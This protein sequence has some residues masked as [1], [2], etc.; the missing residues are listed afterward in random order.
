MSHTSMRIALLSATAVFVA[1]PASSYAYGF[2]NYC[3]GSADIK[4]AGP[5]VET[6][7]P[8]SLGDGSAQ[9]DSYFQTINHYK[10]YSG[11]AIS[12]SYIRPKSDCT[13]NLSDWNTEVALVPRA[14]INGN[15]LTTY[16]HVNGCVC[17]PWGGGNYGAT[18]S[19][20]ASD[21]QFSSPNGS[22]Y[23]SRA[24]GTF[25]GGR[26]TMVHE[27]GHQY[28]LDDITGF[29]MMDNYSTGRPLSGD[30]GGDHAQP[31]SD[32]IAG[33]NA[34]Y[35]TPASTNLFS[36]AQ[37][38]TGSDI[39]DVRTTD[40]VLCYGM[41]VT[42]KMTAVNIGST[43][44]AF[45]QRI[46]LSQQSPGSPSQPNLNLF[47]VVGDSLPAKSNHTLTFTWTI[48]RGLPL[49]VYSLYHQVD[50]DS[51]ISE[52]NENDNWQRQAGT[53]EII[54]CG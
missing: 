21:Q 24:K 42:V 2:A 11:I 13:I 14:S 27:F 40:Q 37:Y 53:L 18:D 34:L 39:A 9:A 8:C 49:G 10:P 33:I 31:F 36:S 12:A 54:D 16:A 5:L 22:H 6:R 17:D 25:G 41:T 43:S 29:A 26:A 4:D 19:Q 1:C 52:V 32:D 35:G 15:G 46:Y 7:N 30:Q 38:W 48:Q 23:T 47:Y 45:H 44:V 28:G 20:I 3:C 50:D 51:K